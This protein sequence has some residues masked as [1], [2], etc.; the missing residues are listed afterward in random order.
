M[1]NQRC[2]Q[3]VVIFLVAL[4]TAVSASIVTDLGDS[5]PHPA[6]VEL[7]GEGG[8]LREHSDRLRDG[9]LTLQKHT[10]A[11]QEH[12]LSNGD[13]E[14]VIANLAEPKRDENPELGEPHGR[15][16]SPSRAN[17]LDGS[18][19]GTSRLRAGNHVD[20]AEAST[21]LTPSGRPNVSKMLGE[22]SRDLPGFAGD[23]NY[24][25]PDKKCKNG[26]TLQNCQCICVN[27][28]GGIKC[29][30]CRI[31]SGGGRRLLA[32]A[33]GDSDDESEDEEEKQKKY[34][35][36]HPPS[37]GSC[38]HGSFVKATC[39]CRCNPDWNGLM[40]DGCK[41]PP[42]QNGG[43]LDKQ[44]CSCKCVGY[45]TGKTC[46]QCKIEGTVPFLETFS[47]ATDRTQM[48]CFHG[49]FIRPEVH[50]HCMIDRLCRTHTVAGLH[51]CMLAYYG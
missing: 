43:R 21:A 51:V 39:S 22:S 18:K 26:G 42:C 32:D 9:Q 23:G 45:W 37:I 8:R 46:T 14:P 7:A 24:E 5:T 17:V 40:C 28:W 25:C 44:S 1:L 10:G 30:V 16:P 2:D 4:S 34:L 36:K 29:G 11:A 50:M 49:D 41:H 15:G 27:G 19:P 31:N 12:N 47:R 13:S 20:R 35:L 33:H 48:K 38:S 3:G 6:R